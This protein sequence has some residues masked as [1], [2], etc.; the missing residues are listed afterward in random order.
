MSRLVR[1]L[2]M[3]A[4]F[5]GVLYQ[6]YQEEDINHCQHQHHNP[7]KYKFETFIDSLI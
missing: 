2:D 1:W 7:Q 6:I 5:I 3:L 4:L